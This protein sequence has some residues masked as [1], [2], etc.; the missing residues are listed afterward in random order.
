MATNDTSLRLIRYGAYLTFIGILTGASIPILPFPRV[1][2]SAHL[3]G[4]VLNGFALTIAG[5]FWGQV[6]LSALLE[7]VTFWLLIF[8]AYSGWVCLFFAA[9]TGASSLLPLA[10]AGHSG[11]PLEETLLKVVL[12]ISSAAFVFGWG[13]VAY[14][15]VRGRNHA[16]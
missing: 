5:L 16:S 8:A 3:G 15:L 1:G 14:G 12:A 11:T 2:V 9:V 13:G 4:G 10:A 7:K 6:R